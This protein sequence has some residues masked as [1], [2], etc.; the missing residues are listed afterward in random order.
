MDTRQLRLL[1]GS[2]MSAKNWICPRASVR[3]LQG[4]RD[5]HEFFLF[6]PE[7]AA[8]EQITTPTGQHRCVGGTIAQRFE[9]TTAAGHLRA[10]TGTLGGTAALSG[11][12]KELVFSIMVNNVVHAA[13]HADIVEAVDSVALAMCA[14]ADHFQPSAKL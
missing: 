9:G 4:K 10:K 14:M 3:L 2:G 6:L 13:T 1:D 12:Y 8:A 5:D 11:Y 7:A